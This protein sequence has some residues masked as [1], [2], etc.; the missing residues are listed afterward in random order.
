MQDVKAVQVLL[1]LQHILQLPFKQYVALTALCI[2]SAAQDF[3][4]VRASPASAH[5]ELRQFIARAAA[6]YT[7]SLPITRPKRNVLAGREAPP[8][9]LFCTHIASPRRDQS[10]MDSCCAQQRDANRCAVV[11]QYC[12]GDT[13]PSARPASHFSLFSAAIT[14]TAASDA[15][16]NGCAKTFLLMSQSGSFN[17]GCLLCGLGLIS[18][19]LVHWRDG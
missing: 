12:L 17:F 15:L 18:C 16:A 19:R 7:A 4:G 10:S 6:A 3:V 2:I 13:V 1:L 8:A 11:D 5:V 9:D 14:A